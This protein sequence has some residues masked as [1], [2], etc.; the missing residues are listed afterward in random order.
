VQLDVTASDSLGHALTYTW[1][2]LTC[3]TLSSNGSYDNPTS[4]T[5]IW[6]APINPNAF[7]AFCSLQ[8]SVSDG[9]GLSRLGFVT[10]GIDPAPPHTLTI[11]AGPSG[12]PNPVASDANVNLSVTA[13]DSLGHNL[14][15]GWTAAC[16]SLTAN[17]TFNNSA[18]RTPAWTAPANETGAQ[19]GCVLHV[20]VNDGNGLSQTGTLTQGVLALPVPPPLAPPSLLVVA[21]GCTTCHSG[22][23]VGYRID[24]TNPGAAF[25]AELR[26]GARLPDGSILMLVSQT[27]TI[28]AGASSMTLVPSEALPTGLPTIDLLVEAAILEPGL[29][30][31]IARHNVPLHLLP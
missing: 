8:V 21:T 11:T 1:S 30:T 12:S 28:P 29:A 18:S 27:V 14:S 15:Y 20:T 6:T 23:A 24:F 4:R 5:P 17:G 22:Q 13:V 9:Q 10:Q 7:R 3:L 25:V 31:T 2:V 26:G 16:S 19:Q